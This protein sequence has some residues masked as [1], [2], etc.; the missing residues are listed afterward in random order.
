V[1]ESPD[2]Q[3]GSA[4][5]VLESPDKQHGSAI[6]APESPNKRDDSVFGRLE[7]GFLP[8][9]IS[10]KPGPA[11][12]AAAGTGVWRGWGRFGGRRAWSGRA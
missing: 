11:P 6:E 7:K 12:N 3:H 4:I 8:R 9:D 10:V 2:K 5:E 1:P